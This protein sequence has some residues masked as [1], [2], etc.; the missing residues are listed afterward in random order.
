MNVGCLGGVTVR[1]SD[2]R[3]SGRRFD[4]RWGRYQATWVNSAFHPSGLGKSSTGLSGW[5]YGGACSL[6]SVE[7]QV[8]LCDPVWQVTPLSS[9]MDSHEELYSAFYQNGI[10]LLHQYRH[11]MPEKRCFSGISKCCSVLLLAVLFVKCF[12]V[13]TSHWLH[14]VPQ[15]PPTKPWWMLDS[16]ISHL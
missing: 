7:W 10:E 16:G 12:S 14:Q 5:A 11:T 15:G 4:S 2:L 6:V 13:L 9:E 3:S 8:T 1:A